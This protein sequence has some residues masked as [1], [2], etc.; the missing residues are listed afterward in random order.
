MSGALPYE[1][2]FWGKMFLLAHNA[3]MPPGEMWDQTPAFLLKNNIAAAPDI[4]DPMSRSTF[5]NLMRTYPDDQQDT[6]N[7]VW[8]P[9][10]E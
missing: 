1:F 4:S 3:A 8:S 7:S 2:D 10:A 9:H 6:M 5:G